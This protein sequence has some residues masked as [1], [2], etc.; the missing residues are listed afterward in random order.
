MAARVGGVTLAAAKGE[1]FTGRDKKS[2]EDKG[3]VSRLEIEEPQATTTAPAPEREWIKV[4]TIARQTGKK[5]DQIDR[6][7][8]K[9]ELATI[10]C[11]SR[12]TETGYEYR[13]IDTPTEAKSG[14]LQ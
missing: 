1:V 2:G 11:E 14:V 7:R 12:E 4:G 6:L 3:D 13:K 9:G 5:R 8:K 10:G